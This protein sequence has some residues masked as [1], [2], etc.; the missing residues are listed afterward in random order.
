M[1]PV[2]SFLDAKP[3]SFAGRRWL[4]HPS[5]HLPHLI[6]ADDEICD[7]I[8]FCITRSEELPFTT[9]TSRLYMANPIIGPPEIN[10]SGSP[11]RPPA[12]STSCL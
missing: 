3:A 6:H 8:S 1:N 10:F 7:T 11:L 4:G 9:G 5:P 2:S 12:A